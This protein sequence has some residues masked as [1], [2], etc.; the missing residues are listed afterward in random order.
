M[1]DPRTGAIT[2]ANAD[3]QPWWV[4][5]D[6]PAS[7]WDNGKYDAGTNRDNALRGTALNDR[8]YGLKGDD[9][10]TGRA[11][12]DRLWGGIGG[13]TIAG[14]AGGDEINGGRGRDLADYHTSGTAVRISL[15]TGDGVGGQAE[16][17]RLTDIEMLRGSGFA[18]RL[19]GNGGRNTIWG[20]RGD[21]T[22]TGGYGADSLSGGGGDDTFVISNPQSAGDRIFGFSNY[23]NDIIMLSASAFGGHAIGG[24]RRD[25]FQSSNASVAR[26]NDTRIIH[27][28]N[29]QQIWFDAD[30]TGSAAAV[31]LATVHQGAV[32]VASDFWFF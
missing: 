15:A 17:D 27:D 16:A 30:G 26:S 6:R 32:I 20:G 3:V 29:D 2:D 14:G 10:L 5:D 19:T 13:D 25:E 4:G 8:L 11:G 18:D 22:I 21:D 31:L 7:N 1:P 28:R 12:D 9:V 24:L 23:G